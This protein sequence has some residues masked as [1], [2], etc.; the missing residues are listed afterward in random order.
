[1]AGHYGCD[2]GVWAA[3]LYREHH[4]ADDQDVEIMILA[5]A[6][7]VSFGLALGVS[8]VVLGAVLDAMSGQRLLGG[9][10]VQWRRVAFA[11]SLF[12][13]WY[14]VPGLAAAAHRSTAVVLFRHLLGE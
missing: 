5:A 8:R 11:A 7:G 9:L 14:F 12:W 6:L 4:R 3:A 2:E 13:L 1:M 10:Q